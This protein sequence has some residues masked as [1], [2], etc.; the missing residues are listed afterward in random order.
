MIFDFTDDHKA[1]CAEILAK[2]DFAHDAALGHEEVFMKDG[3]LVRMDE[4]VQRKIAKSASAFQ[5]V[6]RAF[7][8]RRKYKEQKKAIVAIQR[9]NQ[10][11]TAKKEFKQQRNAASKLAGLS[12]IRQ[13]RKQTTQKRTEYLAARKIESVAR[14]LRAKK[15]AAMLKQSKEEREKKRAEDEEAVRA[16]LQE[17]TAATPNNL[18][19]L[20]EAM[21]LAMELEGFDYEAEATYK[22]AVQV[23]LVRTWRL[24][25]VSGSN[26]SQSQLG[27]PTQTLLVKPYK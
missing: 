16:A 14:Q 10:V 1:A 17:A 27:P 2:V 4:A 15:Q 6:T 24:L 9:I 13:A 8:A 21:A 5:K 19:T 18:V 25:A 23:Q 11:R 20:N 7:I 3:F 22:A 26:R 12:R